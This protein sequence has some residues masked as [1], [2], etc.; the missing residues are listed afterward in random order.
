M[1]I[2]D[3]RLERLVGYVDA[4]PGFQ[5][6]RL[7]RPLDVYPEH[8]AESA[9]QW[10]ARTDSGQ[11]EIDHIYLTVETDEGVAGVAGPLER[12]EF[13]AVIGRQLAPLLIGENPLAHERPG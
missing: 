2:T 11:L 8:D 9:P 1:R 12:Y 3:L 4:P 5:A 10:A 13:A 7:S 6:E